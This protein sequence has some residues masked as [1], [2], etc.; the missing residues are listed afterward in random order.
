MGEMIERK[1][2]GQGDVERVRRHTF[3]APSSAIETALGFRALARL[4]ITASDLTPF[5]LR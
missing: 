1:F 3:P 5:P 4:D 2:E